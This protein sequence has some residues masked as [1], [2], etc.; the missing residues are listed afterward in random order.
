MQPNRFASL[1]TAAFSFA[2]LPF[3]WGAVPEEIAG[4]A[5]PPA[6]AAV[7]TA[8]GAASG[9]TDP[10]PVAVAPDVASARWTDIEHCAYDARVQFFAGLDSLE[11][12]VDNQLR[13]LITKRA[14]MEG[15]AS[16]KDWDF[17]MK[18]MEDARAYLKSMGEEARAAN[19]ETWDQEKA[20]VGQAWTRTQAAYGK[21]KSSTTS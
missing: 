2:A 15:T 6:L 19:R 3:G 12:R 10:L 11:E 9:P 7:A 21:V 17:A 16:L 1:A 4:A 20:K 8:T 5:A 18:E 13:E 14:K